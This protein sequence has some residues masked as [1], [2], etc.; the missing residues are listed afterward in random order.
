MADEKGGNFCEVAV[1]VV[2]HD[3]AGSVSVVIVVDDD[4]VGS[5]ILSVDHF[6]GEFAGASLHK[7]DVANA[8]VPA[9]ELCFVGGGAEFWV[10][11]EGDLSD[12]GFSV[13]YFSEVGEGVFDGGG[14]FVGPAGRTID[15]KNC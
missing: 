2:L 1:A 5:Q 9:F 7:Q 3:H 4:H 11:G 10:V 14:E 8:G 13:G 15:L 12:E 6:L